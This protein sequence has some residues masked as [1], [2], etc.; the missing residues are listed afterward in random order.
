MDFT[1]TITKLTQLEKVW[2]KLISKFTM[3]LTEVDVEYP[4]SLA[5]DFIWDK[6]EFHSGKYHLGEL[7]KAHISCRCT[8][9]K[10]KDDQERIFNNIN[11][12]SVDILSTEGKGKEIL[13]D[14]AKPKAKD[15]AE[16]LDDD[17]PF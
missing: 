13:K 14:N 6:A 15:K 12:W 1:W 17:L 9:Y 7:V 4:K 2:E 11:C 16:T 10:N 3:C 8:I 5:V